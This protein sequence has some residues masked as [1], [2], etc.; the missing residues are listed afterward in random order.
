MSPAGRYSQPTQPLV[1]KLVHPAEHEFPA[2]LAGAG[3]VAGRHVGDLHVRDDRQELLHPLGDV[4]LGGLAVVDV[5]LQAEP[6][7]TDRLDHGRTLRLGVEEIAGHVAVVDRLD[8]H[9]DPARLRLLGGPG[10]IRGIHARGG[11]LGDAG[12][13]D[14]GHGVHQLAAER[15]GVIQRLLH[16]VAELAAGGPA[17]WRG[18]ARPSPSR[19]AAC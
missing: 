11:D 10:E 3:L 1:A 14:A 5:E 17:G 7:A 18:H 8:H 2:D 19:R 12:R 9:L 16:P 4:A 6:V 15:L 13:D